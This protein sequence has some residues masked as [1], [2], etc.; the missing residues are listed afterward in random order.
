MRKTRKR[1]ISAARYLFLIAVGVVTL[2]PLVWLFLATFKTNEEI[3]GAAGALMPEHFSWDAY[4]E[5]W[6]GSGQYTYATFFPQFIFAH[7]ADGAV[8][9]Y[10]SGQQSG[11]C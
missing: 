5:G 4:V 1:V 3:F 2:F 11:V 7:S 6:K 10:E 9:G 8:Y